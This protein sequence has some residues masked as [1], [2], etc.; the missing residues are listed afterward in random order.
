[1]ITDGRYKPNV[2]LETGLLA[3]TVP[4]ACDTGSQLVFLIIALVE[5]KKISKIKT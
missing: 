3:L 4:H 5:H 2:I 1:M